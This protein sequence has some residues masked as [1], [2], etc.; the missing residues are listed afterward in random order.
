MPDLIQMKT[1]LLVD[2]LGSLAAAARQLKIS[3]AAVSKQLTRLEEELGLQLMI[4]TT[5]HVELTEAGV[6]YCA[7]CRRIFEEVE[8]AAALVSNIKALPHGKLK[9]VSGR[10]FGTAYIVPHLSEF[11][12]LYPKIELEL[13]LAERHPDVNAEAIDVLIG[14]SISATGDVIQRRIASTSYTY[15]A[16]PAYL[17]QF[18]MPAKPSD[19]KDHRY[20][21]HSMRKPD[22]EL[23][24]RNRETVKIQPYIRVN[25]AETMLRLALEGL[26]IVRLHHYVVKKHLDQGL[27]R[28]IPM[29]DSEEEIPLY[30]AYPQRRYIA[31]KIRHFIDFT[32]AK[33]NSSA[34]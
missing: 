23:S 6:N 8:A 20:I 4:R 9:V 21:V 1:L 15:C 3:P 11:L 7:Q 19:L 25:D 5:R 30:V 10:H 34:L 27:L 33:M 26:G 13:E 28:A 31:S 18:G 14:M 24:F 16:S 2:D 29:P 32:L 12:T 17:D 22:N